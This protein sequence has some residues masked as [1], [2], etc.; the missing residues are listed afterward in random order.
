MSAKFLQV[1]IHDSYIF[2]SEIEI[3]REKC[4]GDLALVE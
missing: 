4:M 3:Y 1:Q 2:Q